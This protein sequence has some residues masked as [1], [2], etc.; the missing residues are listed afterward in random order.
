MN[1]THAPVK[2]KVNRKKHQ[3]D[4]AEVE[5]VFYDDRAITVEDCDPAEERFVT[6]G[7]DGMDGMDGL[8][9]LLVVA[10]HYRGED[11]LGLF[12]HVWLS[13]TNG[14]VIKRVKR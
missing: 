14:V 5:G 11:D 2:N 4:L 13:H 8:G 7:M 9:R 10:Y 1:I 3:I 6:L 12:P